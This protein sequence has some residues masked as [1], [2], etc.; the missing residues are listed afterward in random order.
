MPKALDK[1]TPK[2]HV[3]NPASLRAHDGPRI[4]HKLAQ[5]G[6]EAPAVGAVAG[7][8]DAVGA[9]QRAQRARQ[10]PPQRRV[11]LPRQQPLAC[12][13]TRPSA[14]QHYAGRH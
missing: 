14:W 11:G 13:C 6:A 8:G 3:G 9:G 12:T 2:S 5:V 4:G 1:K 10:L 7:G